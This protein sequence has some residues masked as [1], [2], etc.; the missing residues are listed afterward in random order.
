MTAEPLLGGMLAG[1]IGGWEVFLLLVIVLVIV[2]PKLLV[3][4]R[5]LTERVR[6]LAEHPRRVIPNLF[7]LWL[8]EGFGVGRIPAAP[9]TFGSLVGL[10]WFLGLLAAGQLWLFLVLLL[11]GVLLSVLC[12]TVAER[13]LGETDPPSVV[14]DEIVAVPLCFATSVCA[15][16][17]STGQMPAPESFF[18]R[19]NWPITLAVFVAFRFFDVVKPWPVRQSQ[20]LPGGWGITIDDLL[21][22]V[23]VN[24]LFLLGLGLQATLR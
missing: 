9:G 3:R 13:I 24:L 21:A 18:S 7:F 15:E 14:L 16:F 17:F 1:V 12:C 4:D 11:V 6:E 8:A 10:L 19:E 20:R 23:Y 5:A 2:F 22:A